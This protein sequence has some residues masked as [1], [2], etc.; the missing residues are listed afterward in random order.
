MEC[1]ACKCDQ[2]FRVK[3][4]GYEQGA[5]HVSGV[6]VRPLGPNAS[7][8]GRTLF[9][10]FSCAACDQYQLLYFVRFSDDGKTIQKVGQ[11][12][13]PSVRLSKELEKVLGDNAAHYR[14]GRICENQGYGIAAFAY[15]RRIVETTIGDLLSRLRDILPESNKAQFTAALDKAE[16]SRVAQEKIDLVKDLLPDSLRPDGLNPLGILHHALSDGLHSLQD[17][18]CLGD[19]LKVRHVLEFLVKEIAAAETNK[20]EF[21]GGMRKLLE[22]KSPK[23]GS[24]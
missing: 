13:A 15:Y 5:K 17:A 12:P 14:K 6:G 8:A 19:A 21:T 3:S 2:T 24:T 1:L 4:T 22:K 11:F 7:I 20:R 9:V 18:A 10:L 16:N 23:D